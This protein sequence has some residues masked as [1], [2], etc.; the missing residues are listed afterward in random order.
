MKLLESID[1]YKQEV[2]TLKEENEQ[3][4]MAIRKEIDPK[5]LAFIERDNKRMAESIAL[6]ETE[7]KNT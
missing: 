7:I 1:I 6:L 4:E 5:T 3:F 2:A